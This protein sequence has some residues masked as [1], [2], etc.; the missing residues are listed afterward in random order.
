MGAGGVEKHA[1]FGGRKGGVS[2]GRIPDAGS[3]GC[4][5]KLSARS[6]E[7]IQYGE[8]SGVSLVGIS[9]NQMGRFGARLRAA[10]PFRL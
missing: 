7:R 6:K 4:R 2:G 1:A 10:G 5:G 3:Y 8:V 9:A